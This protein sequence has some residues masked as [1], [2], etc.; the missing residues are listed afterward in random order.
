MSDVVTWV[1]R[2]YFFTSYHNT[3]LE[4]ENT[5]NLQLGRYSTAKVYL[6]PLFDDAVRDNKDKNKIYKTK[7]HMKEMLTFGLALHW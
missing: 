1:S 4:F 2:T 3:K 6:Y 7:W 5:F